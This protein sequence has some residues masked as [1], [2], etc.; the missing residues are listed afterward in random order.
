MLATDGG[1]TEPCCFRAPA[2]RV[3]L[4]WTPLWQYYWF[5]VVSMFHRTAMTVIM[6]FMLDYTDVQVISPL[7]CHKP[8][9]HAVLLPEALQVSRQYPLHIAMQGP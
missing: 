3:P 4:P 2:D 9:L 7:C 8:M 1:T 6:V 5:E